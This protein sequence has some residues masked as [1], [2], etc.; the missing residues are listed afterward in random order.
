MKNEVVITQ[1]RTQHPTP[2]L[3]PTQAPLTSGLVWLMAITCGLVVANIYYNQ[4]LLVEIGRT[5]QVSDSR[6]SWVATITQVGYTLGLLFAVPLGDKVER[7]GLILLLLLCAAACLAGAALA[8][9]FVV[10]VAASLLI[11]IFSAVP[12]LLVPMAASLATDAERGKVVGKVMSGLL[13]GILLSRTLSGYVGAHFGWRTMF[14]GGALMM[15]M[16]VAILALRLPRNQPSFT[17]TY[18]SLMKSLLTLTR[19]L[20]TLRRSSLVGACMFGGLTVFWTTL[21]FFLEGEPYFYKSD[22]VGFFGVI[23]A[24]GALA[25]PLA[26]K[27]ADKRGSDYALSMGILLALGAYLLLGLTG[28]YLTGLILGVIILDVG[29]QVTHISNQS[30]IFSLIPEARSRLNTVYMTSSFIGGSLG[31]LAGGFAWAHWQWP[32]VCATGLLFVVAAFL[33]N[34]FYGRTES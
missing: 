18:S 13:I 15:L 12:Q 11:G 9:S 22:V 19:D 26:G 16:L 21:V 3:P 29:Q 25:A 24:C 8:P 27:L 34:R 7:K 5:F 30:R 32:G 4:P 1:N 28:V 6:V 2:V 31:S 14:G 17:G 23:G 20:P 10:L 33:I